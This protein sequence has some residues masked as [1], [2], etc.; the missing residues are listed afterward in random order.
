MRARMLASLKCR[1]CP[2][3]MV[4]GRCLFVFPEEWGVN[5]CSELTSLTVC[6]EGRLPIV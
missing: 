4:F 3:Q 1:G 6:L 5:S 2:R